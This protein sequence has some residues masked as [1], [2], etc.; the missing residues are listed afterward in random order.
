MELAVLGAGV[1]LADALFRGDSKAIELQQNEARQS[2]NMLESH[3][4]FLMH[5]ARENGMIA[6]QYGNVATRV[7]W[8]PMTG[9]H[10][11]DDLRDSDPHTVDTENLYR[12]V[13]NTRVHESSDIL[14]HVARNRQAFARKAG[15]PLWFAFTPEVSMEQ[16][17]RRVSSNIGQYKWVPRNP[18]D[19]DYSYAANMAK[20][21]PRDPMLFTPDA[22]FATAPGLPFRYSSTT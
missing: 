7:P 11:L 6:P 17:G 5:E 16:D 20:L 4:N 12:R 21:V 3:W 8:H 10:Y 18:H 15:N 13:A 19:S 14:E 1:Y 22:N 2:E 9:V